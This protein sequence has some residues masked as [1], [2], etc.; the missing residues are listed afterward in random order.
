MSKPALSESAVF[1]LF[2]LTTS[3]F[4][5]IKLPKV[6][7]DPRSEWMNEWSVEMRKYRFFVGL[8]LLYVAL[9]NM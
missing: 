7:V 1:P 5:L 6:T 4:R 8:G 3:V 9:T 2:M